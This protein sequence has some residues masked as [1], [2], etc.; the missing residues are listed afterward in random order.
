MLDHTIPRQNATAPN[1]VTLVQN[2][3]VETEIGMRNEELGSERWTTCATLVV[4]QQNERFG[5]MIPMGHG[6]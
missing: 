6:Q 2:S 4:T 1:V 3:R 5:D